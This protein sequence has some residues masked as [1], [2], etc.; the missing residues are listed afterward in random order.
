MKCVNKSRPSKSI[1]SRHFL[2]SIGDCQKNHFQQLQTGRLTD[3]YS[4]LVIG[5]RK[6]FC[7]LSLQF[8]LEI[9]FILEKGEFL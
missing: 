8:I 2:E 7:N 1:V 5:N 6:K 4:L 3:L 9:Q